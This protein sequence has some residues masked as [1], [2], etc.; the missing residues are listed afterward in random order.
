M[1]REGLAT[2][3][4]GA[5]SDHAREALSEPLLDATAAA[6]LLAVR[7]SWIYEAVRAGRLPHVKI[8]RHIRFLRSDLESW[9]ATRRVGVTTR[10]PAQ[11]LQ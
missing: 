7:P 8:G 10:S 9:V 11:T 3:A 4:F 6:E 1:T 5:S 2:A